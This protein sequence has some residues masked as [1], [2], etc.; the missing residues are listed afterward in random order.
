MLCNDL[1]HIILHA[2]SL[3]V[4]AKIYI[5]DLC[6]LFSYFLRIYILKNGEYNQTTKVA[7]KVLLFWQYHPL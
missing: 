3:K 4:A 2:I 7:L 6:P 5:E 1:L